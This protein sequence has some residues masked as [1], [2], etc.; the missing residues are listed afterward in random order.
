MASRHLDIES[1]KK[2][3]IAL[4]SLLKVLAHPQRLLLLCCLRTGEKTVSE[5]ESVCGT[6]Q[7]VVSQHLTRMRLEGFVT[8][9][10]DGNFVYYRII[11]YRLSTLMENMQHLFAVKNLKNLK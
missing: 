3:C 6:S 10:R 7:S 2:K 8:S 4:A 9:R 5:L 11:D 1:T